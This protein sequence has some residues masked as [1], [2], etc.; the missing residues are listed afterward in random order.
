MVDNLSRPGFKVDGAGAR[1]ADDDE[2]FR[3]LFS[4][5]ILTNFDTACIMKQFGVHRRIRGGKSAMFPVLG[6]AKAEW[7]AAGDDMISDVTADGNPYLST[8]PGS[9]VEVHV[10]DPIV[11]PVLI[12][13]IDELKNAFDLRAPYAR[14]LGQALAH[15]ADRNLMAV[16]YDAADAS[17][18]II[19]GSQGTDALAPIDFG[20]VSGTPGAYT[21]ANLEAFAFDCAAE[22]D[23]Q[24]LPT[25]GRRLLVRPKMYWALVESGSKA[26]QK[27]Y[28]EG[29][30]DYAKGVIHTLAGMPIVTCPEFGKLTTDLTAAT[31]G[32]NDTGSRNGDYGRDWT[33]VGALAFHNSAY[34]VLTMEDVAL[35]TSWIPWRRSTFT[36]A[37]YVMGQKMLR[38]DAAIAGLVADLSGT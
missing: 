2:L 4:N 16:L 26:I 1:G 33:G 7:H 29:N 10:D 38:P 34:G 25:E 19:G 30:G 13:R 31:T 8:I 20:G 18:A 28:S 37:S 21:P 27:E 9:E 15:K 36:V 35:E 14:E 24:G 6:R 3:V 5:E 17:A 22:M 12:P 32:I 11:S 23:T